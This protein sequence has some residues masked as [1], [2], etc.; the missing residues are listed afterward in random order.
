MVEGTNND[1]VQY[2]E[3][4]ERGVLHSICVFVLESRRSLNPTSEQ[5]QGNQTSFVIFTADQAIRSHLVACT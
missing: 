2:L 3:G 1:W 4:M 5:H